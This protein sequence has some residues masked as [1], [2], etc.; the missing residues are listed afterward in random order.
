MRAMAKTLLLL[1]AFVFAAAV[2]A[3]AAHAQSTTVIVVRHAEKVDDS[4]DPVL[5]PAGTARAVALADALQHANVEVVLTTQYRR[6]RLTAAVVAERAGVTPQVVAAVNP[7]EDHLRGLVDVVGV[8]AG[9]TI[10]IVGH[11]NTVPLI[12]RALG[13]PDVGTIEDGEYGNLFVLTLS[14]DLPT[15]LVRARY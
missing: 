8:N 7:M 14:A 4:A 2:A 11:S 3:S 12:V 13:G 10:L 9:R 5:S 6:T 1:L 15:R